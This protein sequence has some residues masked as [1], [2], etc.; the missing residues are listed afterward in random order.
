VTVVA[1]EG[2]R[3]VAGRGQ[4]GDHLGGQVWRAPLVSKLHLLSTQLGLLLKH[5]RKHV[6]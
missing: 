5:R 1:R 3:L 2:G 4:L 6:K